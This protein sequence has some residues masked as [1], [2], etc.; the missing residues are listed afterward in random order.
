M[1]LHTCEKHKEIVVAFLSEQCPLCLA[2]EKIAELENQLD[3]ARAELG[4]TGEDRRE[5]E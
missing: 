3:V 4:G 1:S 5:E 2:Q